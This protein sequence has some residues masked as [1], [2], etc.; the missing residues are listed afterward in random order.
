MQAKDPGKVPVEELKGVG[1]RRA[2]LLN[3]LGIHT[4]GELLSHWPRRYEDRRNLK[5]LSGLLPGS[6]ETVKVK[7]MTIEEQKPRRGLTITRAKVTDGAGVAT[8][9]WFNQPY[10]ARY[11]RREAEVVITGRVRERFRMLELTVQDYEVVGA[12]DQQNTG[13]LVPF[14][15]ATA[16]V[17]QRFLRSL[18]FQALR[19]FAAGLPEVLPLEIRQR[20]HLVGVEDAC[21]WMHFPE[22]FSQQERAQK[23]QVFEELLQFQLGLLLLRREG[24]QRGTGIAHP[25]GEELLVRFYRSLPYNLTPAQQRVVE[26]IARDMQSPEP[27]RRLL[28]GD[29]GS[30]KTVVAATAL[31]RAVS[32]GYQGALMA[33][34]E[35]LAEQHYLNLKTL[36]SPL[37]I[38]VALLKGEMSRG[39]KE[40]MLASISSGE[41]GVVV[42]THALIQEGVV[43][44]ALSLAITDEQH[45]FGVRQRA[46]LHQ[47]GTSPDVL[48]MTATPIPRTLALT[49]YG[50][51][52]LSVIDELPPGRQ[53]VVTRFVPEGKRRQVYDF[54]RQQVDQGRQA[55]VVC[56]LVEESEVLQVQAAGELAEQLA[57]DVLAGYQVGLVHGKLKTVEKE[58]VMES[59]RRGALQVLVATTVVEV[60]VDV[61][62]ASVMVIEG[63]ERFGLAQ[64]HQL[65]GRVGRGRHKSYCLLLGSPKTLEARQR[66]EV[67]S[68]IYDGFRI[69]E[70]DL[71]IR[72]PGD[73][74]GTR[75]HGLPELKVADLVRDAGVLELAR[76]EAAALLA[77]DPYLERSEWHQFYQVVH[78]NFSQLEN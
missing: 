24:R 60:G 64:L 50:D 3:D 72:G 77:A 11:L 76:R 52:D 38:Q 66:M 14:Y 21:R 71:K 69:A 9:I 20:Y 46:G 36:L 4:V 41:A 45:R 25:S 6:V 57:K 67:I 56:P 40:A 43:F 15:P 54:V 30:G 8:A 53:P 33:P 51:L 32:G 28:Q 23:R 44:R 65:R 47:K 16:Q 48:V 31:V 58:A 34:T 12:G 39:D 29:V 35:I 61:P 74:F 68:K 18:I 13:R 1:A 19:E 42:G 63:A 55:Y 5:T 49:L 27:M 70:E 75:Q 7:V 17:S 22:E 37:G 59:F 26:E 73:L 2:R 62:N 10:V 78:K